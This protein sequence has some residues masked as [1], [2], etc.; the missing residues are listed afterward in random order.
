MAIVV[1]ANRFDAIARQLVA[2]WAQHD[3]LLLTCEDLSTAGW[4]YTCGGATDDAMS[5]AGGRAVISGRALAVAEIMGVYTRTPSIFPQELTQI[6]PPDREYIAAEMTAFLT[7][8]LSALPCV[9]VSRPTASSLAGPGWR[10]EEWFWAAVRAGLPIVPIHSRVAFSPST[11][12]TPFTP[13]TAL[14]PHLQPLP[15]TSH[16]TL[17]LV[18]GRCFDPNG[19]ELDAWDPRAIIA[20]RLAR[21]GGVDLLAV[22]LIASPPGWAINGVIPWPNDLS[23]GVAEA[24]CAHLTTPQRSEGD[25]P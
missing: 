5:M 1:V 4:R 18:G 10:P 12:F 7:W 20:Q 13:S 8:W 22:Q 17:T 19:E 24:L 25:A 6:G 16:L 15:H 2:R 14:T 3:A 9:V 11:P 21:A 23:D